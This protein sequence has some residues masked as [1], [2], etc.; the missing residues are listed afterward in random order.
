MWCQERALKAT[1]QAKQVQWELGNTTRYAVNK[2]WFCT[3]VLFQFCVHVTLRF[4]EL[5]L[6]SFSFFLLWKCVLP[7]EKSSELLKKQ[8]ILGF[9]P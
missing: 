8:L 3:G 6:S 4:V 7:V 5:F 9:S 2:S 1:S